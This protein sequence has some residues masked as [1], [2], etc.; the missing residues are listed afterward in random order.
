MPFGFLE[1]F[2][3][4]LWLKNAERHKYIRIWT[5]LKSWFYTPRPQPPA[6]QT[7]LKMHW[8]MWVNSRLNVYYVH[9]Q[10]IYASVFLRFA[11][12][13]WLFPNCHEWDCR[14]KCDNIRPVTPCRLLSSTP[15]PP[16]H[17]T[18]PHQ[19]PGNGLTLTDRAPCHSV[20]D[21]VG[22]VTSA[23]GAS[24]WGVHICV[25]LYFSF[26]FTS[27]RQTCMPVKCM[28]IV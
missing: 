7:P 12:R 13:N 11:W 5:D 1:I 8:W 2:L 17:P 24:V 22:C 3:N 18:P 21:W 23:S 26:E 20:I 9:T 28:C 6:P 16:P 27:G 25:I 15:H 10:I 19:F 14:P 4:E